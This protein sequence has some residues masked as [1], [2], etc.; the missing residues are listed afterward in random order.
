M[1]VPFESDADRLAELQALGESVIYTPLGGDAKTIYVIF[2]NVSLVSENTGK[3]VGSRPE[4]KG[5]TIDLTAP[6]VGGSLL[7]SGTTYT[8]K[9]NLPD[10]TGMTDM[11]LAE[12]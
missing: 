5:R 2:D 6:V 11:E 12:A 8:I 3:V 9:T 10:D 7:I 1:G 4:A